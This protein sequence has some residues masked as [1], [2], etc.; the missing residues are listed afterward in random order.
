MLVRLIDPLTVDICLPALRTIGNSLSFTETYTDIFI[1]IGIL[2]YMNQLLSHSQCPSQRGLLCASPLLKKQK[3]NRAN[4]AI[5][6]S[7]SSNSQCLVIRKEALGILANVCT[8]CQISLKPQLLTIG[9]SKPFIAALLTSG[10]NLTISMS[11]EALGN[12]LANVEKVMNPEALL[13][14]VDVGKVVR[15]RK[16][17]QNRGLA[18]AEGL[19]QGIAWLVPNDNERF[20]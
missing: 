15:K 16:K 19:L 8:F 5:R 3:Y 13:S 7:P 11:I 2:G 18:T 9:I 14:Y 10:E 17:L 12:L 1:G 20:H 6:Y 4:S